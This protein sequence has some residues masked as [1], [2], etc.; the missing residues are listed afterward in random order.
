MHSV[1]VFDNGYF[2]ASFMVARLSTGMRRF[3][4]QLGFHTAGFT[5]FNRAFA[6]P[7]WTTSA[8]WW[9]CRNER[10]TPEAIGAAFVDS[11]LVIIL[12]GFLAWAAAGVS[13]MSLITRLRCAWRAYWLRGDIKWLDEVIAAYQLQPSRPGGN[14]CLIK[15]RAGHCAADPQRN[16]R[17]GV[18]AL[19]RFRLGVID[20]LPAE[21]YHSTHAMS[22][23][24]LKR[25]RISPAH[26]YGLQLDPS[27]AS[28]EP[29]PAMRNGTL[30][31]CALFEPDEVWTSATS[32]SLPR[33]ISGP[34]RQGL[35]AAQRA[36]IVES[37]D[38]ARAQAQ[39]LAVRSQP[40]LAALLAEGRPEV[41]AFWL[42]EQTGELC[43]CRPDW[44]SPAGDGVILVD[45]KTCRDASPEGFGRAI[46]NLSYH[47]QA[48]WYTDGYERASGLKVYGFV[49][50]AV[51]S[52]WP[53]VAAG[54]ML[55]DDVLD[56]A[57]RE[58][59]RLLNLYAE[60]RRTGKWPGYTAG[61]NLINLPAWAQRQLETNE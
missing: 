57:R 43:K 1:H 41:S 58:N 8:T 39:A 51:E 45:G 36:E 5:T 27:P 16:G 52:D 32:S 2:A 61:I 24:G 59:R 56:A 53:H 33:S 54:Y 48:A 42:D 40:D 31:H 47:L 23:G 22:A 11:L 10:R 7:S 50:A 44:V 18:N 12:V 17:A 26:F 14:Q 28:G 19:T 21:E 25:M 49:F 9:R 20:D 3:A 13:V 29:S 55:G 35:E 46:W 34:G 37:A 60:C 15:Q 6:M 38:L 4:V 30:T